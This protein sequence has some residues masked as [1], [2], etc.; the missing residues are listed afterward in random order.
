MNDL[1]EQTKPLKI[2]TKRNR[3][4]L[5]KMLALKTTSFLK[6]VAT[7]DPAKPFEEYYTEMA[8]TIALFA[9][10]NIEIMENC[11]NATNTKKINK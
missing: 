9:D 1:N 6:Q 7:I 2:L 4:K 3:E 8:K 11:I 5:A 10:K